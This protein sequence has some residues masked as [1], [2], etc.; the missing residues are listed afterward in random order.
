[1]NQ[2]ITNITAVFKYLEDY[3]RDI[4]IYKLTLLLLIFHYSP[5]WIIELP[6]RIAALFM[7]FSH[8]WARNPWLWAILVAGTC[9]YT[10]RYWFMVDN[11]K[12]LITYWVGVCYISTLFNDRI[13]V[14]KLNAWLLITLVFGF[15]VYWK[16]ASPDFMTGDFMQYTMLTDSR[17][18]YITTFFTG[19]TPAQFIDKRLLMEFLSIEP[20]LKTKV[21]LDTASNLSVVAKVITWL[22]LLVELAIVLF[23]ALKYFRFFNRFKDYSLQ[24]FILIL[25]PFLPVIGFGFILSILGLAQA[26]EGKST[27]FRGYLIALFIMQIASQL[28]VLYLVKGD[29][30]I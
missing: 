1:M 9:I 13:Q 5:G 14:L 6:V 30:S 28:S 29:L 26:E 7:F 12:F 25:Y 22:T 23:F 8:R 24:F 10:F 19:I 20:N 27:E 17:M 21:T 15:A 3:P 18:Q 2:L 4:L 16:L 11:H